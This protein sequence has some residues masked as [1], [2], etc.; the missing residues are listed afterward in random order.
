MIVKTK[1]DNIN[2]EYSGQ[3]G[4]GGDSNNK[5]RVFTK[6]KTS[7]SNNNNITNNN[8]DEFEDD[9]KTYFDA[10]NSDNDEIVNK[11]RKESSHNQRKVL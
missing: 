5:S 4:S 7:F 10:S 1:I 3:L 6:K 9:M 11:I 8:D 2:K